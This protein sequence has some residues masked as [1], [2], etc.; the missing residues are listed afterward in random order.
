MGSMTAIGLV[1]VC[2]PQVNPEAGWTD[3]E[4]LRA[5]L[6][7][8]GWSFGGVIKVNACVIFRTKPGPPMRS[9]RRCWLFLWLTRF[10]QLCLSPLP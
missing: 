7:D 5:R 4:S 10:Q 3:A 2:L 6:L 9:V 8:H 1:E